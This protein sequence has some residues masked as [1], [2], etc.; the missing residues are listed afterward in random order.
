MKLSEKI[1]AQSM[2]IWPRYL[3]HPFVRE[4][5]E[6][7]LPLEKFRYYMMQDYVYLR[8][9]VKAFAISITKSDN[10]EEINFLCK[11]LACTI[12]E[13][14]RVHVPYMRRL[15]ITE[16]EIEQVVPHID[17]SSYTHY[18]ICEADAGNVL[19][20]L[21]AVLNCSWAYAY[22]AENMVK[23]YPNAVKHENYGDWFAGYVCEEY[24]QA[25][26][27]LIDTIDRLSENISQEET[28]KLCDISR[29]CCQYDL[30]FWDMVYS[31]GNNI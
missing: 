16:Q 22:I 14:F 1:Y 15:G 3:Q 6:G 17:N 28:E 31:M 27:E 9:Y 8:D 18:M 30:R 7:T 25:N 11:E 29:K 26:Q 12:E 21:V 13:T 2:E 10:F 4:M 19:T 23:E 5:A 24:R 20:G